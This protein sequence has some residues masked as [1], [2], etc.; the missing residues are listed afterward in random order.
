MNPEIFL[1]TNILGTQVLL[2]IARKHWKTRPGDKYCREYKPV[3]VLQAST[4]EVYG[5]LGKTGMFAESSPAAEQPVLRLQSRRGY[6]GKG[7][8]PDLLVCR[9][10]VTR[11]SNNYGPYQ[12]PEKLIP[13]L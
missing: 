5:A 11:S 2:D 7:I 9:L 6:D 4:D 13:A 10:T 3:K 8:L 1:T 12:F